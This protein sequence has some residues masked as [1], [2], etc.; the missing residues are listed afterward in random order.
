[1]QRIWGKPV[2]QLFTFMILWTAFACL[3]ALLL[4][5]SRVP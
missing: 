3:Y 2:A 5:Y 1:M 4:G